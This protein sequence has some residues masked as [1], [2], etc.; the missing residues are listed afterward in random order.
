MAKPPAGVF[1]ADRNIEYAVSLQRF[2]AGLRRKV[3]GILKETELDIIRALSE[4]DPTAVVRSSAKTNRLNSVLEQTQ[5][6]IGR[7]YTGIRRE[8]RLELRDLAEI[9]AEFYNKTV[10]AALGVEL[11]A[12]ALPPQLV[13]SIASD[14]LLFGAIQG[15][16]WRSQSR[17]LQNRFAREMRM[18]LLQGEN[19]GQLIRRVRGTSTGRRN[20]YTLSSGEQRT[21]TEFAGG[22]MDTD[23]RHAASLV[24]T[25]VQSV[26]QRARQVIYEENQDVVK[27]VQILATL[28][29][30]TTDICKSLSGLTWFMDASGAYVPQGHLRGFPGHP[31]YHWACRS[32]MIPVLKSWEELGATLNRRQKKILRGAPPGTQA[33]LDGQV[34]GDLNYEQWLR[35]KSPTFQRR[36]LGP[37]KYDLWSKNKITFR[38]LIDETN[39]PLTVRQLRELAAR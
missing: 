21:Y 37:G 28:D 20:R 25:S 31:P 11:S 23:T 9:E 6:T 32:Q 18:G 30:R 27:G 22:L 17:A 39:R 1:I 34:S 12:V 35:T 5:Q 13:R 33:S 10:N 24:R 36:V 16:W 19:L 38:D 14:T 26:S 2:D 7:A 29:A 4:T 3:K 15:D 8:A